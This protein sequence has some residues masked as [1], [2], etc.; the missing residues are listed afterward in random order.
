VKWRLHCIGA[1]PAATAA[2][3]G[4]ETTVRDWHARLGC[5]GSAGRQM[6]FVV[7]G[8]ERW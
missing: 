1:D 3:Y 4:V 5:S 2:R 8:T 6:E 7:T